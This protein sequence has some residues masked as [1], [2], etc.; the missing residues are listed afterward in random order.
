MRTI[1]C[2][3]ALV[4][5]AMYPSTWAQDNKVE[6]AQVQEPDFD[7]VFH[8]LGEDKSLIALE[9]KAAVVTARTKIL[10]GS[11]SVQYEL[12][13]EKSHVR[14]SNGDVRFV[15]RGFGTTTD[16]TQ[17][18][19]MYKLEVK[20]RRRELVLSKTRGAFMPGPNVKFGEGKIELLAARYGSSSMVLSVPDHLV[21]GE[22]AFLYGSTIFA[23]G[24]DP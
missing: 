3:F 12:P 16:P 17:F 2:L 10:S 6:Q 14:F 21:P 20:K 13:S 9:K 5:S 18:V 15:V 11:N 23:F 4:V 22:Y 1:G 24:I 7:F 8:A 19:S